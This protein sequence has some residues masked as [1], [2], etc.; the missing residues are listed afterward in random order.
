MSVDTITRGVNTIG[1]K[2]LDQESSREQ[3]S[4]ERENRR[5]QERKVRNA[6]TLLEERL[7]SSLVDYP[8]CIPQC[9]EY[10]G[11]E[12]MDDPVMSELLTQIYEESRS[13]EE[14]DRH[15]IMDQWSDSSDYDRVC[16]IVTEPTVFEGSPE[17]QEE[18]GADKEWISGAIAQTI[19]KVAVAGRERRKNALIQNG[20]DEGMIMKLAME[21]NQLKQHH[22]K[23][24][25]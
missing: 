21:V 24:E 18:H 1:M 12:D 3:Q 16:S 8:G 23:I 15:R 14:I 4:Q 2:Q 7:I 25:I 17:I 22:V 6:G 13:N 9:M 10:V 20:G 5:K 11:P 19:E